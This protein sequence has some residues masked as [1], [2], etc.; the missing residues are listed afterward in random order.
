[1]LRSQAK[2][3]R[4]GKAGAGRFDTMSL[5]LSLLWRVSET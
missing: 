3:N 5:L 1:M 4:P 2:K